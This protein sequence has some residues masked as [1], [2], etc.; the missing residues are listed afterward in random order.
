MWDTDDPMIFP[1]ICKLC[2]PDSG[3][4]PRDFIR[5]CFRSANCTMDAI[6]IPSQRTHPHV[7]GIPTTQH[8]C[9]SA[10]T[11]DLCSMAALRDRPGTMLHFFML[12]QTLVTRD[13][14]KFWTDSGLVHTMAIHAFSVEALFILR[15]YMIMWCDIMLPKAICSWVCFHNWSH[16]SP[17]WLLLIM[18]VMPAH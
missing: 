4:S 12:Q 11:G 3:N 6:A 18:H 5:C 14:A 2:I 16:V 10:W 13:F 17:L 9:R 1:Y 8:A 15:P 7:P